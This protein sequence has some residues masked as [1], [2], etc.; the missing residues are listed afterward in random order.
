MVGFKMAVVA[1]MALVCSAQAQ[2]QE[3]LAPAP[4]SA[5]GAPVMERVSVTPV[6]GVVGAGRDT[7]KPTHVVYVE[8]HEANQVTCY[9]LILGTGLTGGIDCVKD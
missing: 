7:A 2:A 8:R 4:P 5:E 1:V 6:Y 3:S 9:V